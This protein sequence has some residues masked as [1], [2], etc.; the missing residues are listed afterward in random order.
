MISCKRAVK[1][2]QSLSLCTPH[3]PLRYH[4]REHIFCLQLEERQRPSS[5]SFNKM[6]K[7]SQLYHYVLLFNSPFLTMF[8]L[9]WCR[10]IPLLKLCLCICSILVKEICYSS[11]IPR[12]SSSNTGF[13]AEPRSCAIA[14][15][16]KNSCQG[17]DVFPFL[18][19][20]F[21]KFAMKK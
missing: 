5:M 14:L 21:Q 9:Y 6:R 10:T 7:S 19:L 3:C 20:R 18:L 12:T 13:L 15:F 17:W 1:L 8:S 16:Y 11:G 4:G 2:S